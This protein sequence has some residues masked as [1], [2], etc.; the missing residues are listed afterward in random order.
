MTQFK[1]ITKP[2]EVLLT[3][4]IS[5]LFSSITFSQNFVKI[6]DTLNPVVTDVFSGTYF[7]TS[8]V[9]VDNDGKLDLYVNL[10]LIHI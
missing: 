5:F 4:L 3:V 2:S 8:W 9:D 10:S 7:G 6:T 1:K